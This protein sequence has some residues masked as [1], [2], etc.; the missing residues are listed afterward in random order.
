MVPTPLALHV[1]ELL[2][3]SPSLHLFCFFD[4]RAPSAL[5]AAEVCRLV[6]SRACLAAIA[7]STE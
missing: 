6:L 5:A 3:L 4:C 7:R 2:L 1:S